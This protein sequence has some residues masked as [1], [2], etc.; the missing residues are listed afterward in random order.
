MNHTKE[1]FLETAT[2]IGA[3][4]CRDA[5]W[6]EQRCN[7]LGPSMEFTDNAWM[8]VHRAY[9]ADLYSGTAGIALFLAHLYKFTHDK[10]HRL[11]A[12]GGIAQAL[13]RCE[14]LSP[15][16]RS[17]F[18]SGW[19]GIAYSLVQLA[20]IFASQYLIEQALRLAEELSKDDPMQ[21][22]L[23]VISG[24]AGAIP[25]LLYLHQ[26]QP[27][28]FLVELAI[29]HGN[30]LLD[31]ALKS[32]EG[33]SWNT[34]NTPRNLTGFSHGTAGIGWAF[35]ELYGVTGEEKFQVAA[36]QA[37]RYEQH[38]FSAEQDN[39]P[40]FRTFGEAMPNANA[41]LSYSMAWCHGAPGIGL[42]RLRAWELTGDEGYRQEAEAALR[43]TT[44]TLANS[45]YFSQANFSLCH[46][47]TGNAELLLYAHRLWQYPEALE[48]VERLGD[49]GIEQY[50]KNDLPWPCGVPGA[51]E[52]PNLMLGL[53]G[54][55]YFYL[56]LYHLEEVPSILII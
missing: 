8:A 1:A 29:R 46:G 55:G 31:T 38:W 5:V 16:A 43:S 9:G 20:E 3:K 56:R 12:E 22:G 24:S 51:G 13:S 34:L 36:T 47:H 41:E 25:A 6:H 28:D 44:K 40:D 32:D 53:S 23:D 11:T 15:A 30:H 17:G 27:Q 50:R 39:W 37:C 35:L 42:A 26:K 49:F 45:S 4:V 18:Y 19:S 52:T 7:W 48:T 21:Q 10:I 54:I 2:F 14:Q 33:W